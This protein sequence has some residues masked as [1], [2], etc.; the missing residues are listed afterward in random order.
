MGDLT[1]NFSRSE[2]DVSGPV[3]LEDQGN[4]PLL[5]QLLQAIRDRLNA[6]RPVGLPPVF[7][8]VTSCYRDPAH[9]HAV[10]ASIPNAQQLPAYNGS[11][12][13]RAAAA[14]C[15]FVGATDREIVAA[16]LDDTSSI[17]LP[18]FHQVIVY[19]DLPHAHVALPATDGRPNGEL[20][21][22]YKDAQGDRLYS[23]VTAPGDVPAVTTWATR[24]GLAVLLAVAGAVALGSWLHPLHHLIA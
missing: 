21:L 16:V 14:D 7:G 12:H 24:A 18:A 13:L 3:P 1:R 11:D 8:I 10:Y 15:V 4:V 22:G 2:F 5:A 20:L 17:A 6:R 19:D 23:T 9:N